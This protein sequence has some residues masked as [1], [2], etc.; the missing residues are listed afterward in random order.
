[1]NG[2]NF[3]G[4]ALYEANFSWADLSGA[5]L[6]RANLTHV[7]FARANLSQATIVEANLSH[8]RFH[9]TDLS[10]AQVADCT[11]H[12]ITAWS[13]NLEGA[14]QSNLTITD[15]YEYRVTVDN[16]AVAQF[17][18]LL[19]NNED[20]RTILNS[21]SSKV[22]LILGRFAPERK[23][24]LDRI[25][26]RLRQLDYLPV[27]FDFRQPSNRDLTET[28]TTLAHMAR[29]II[30][31]ITDPKSVPQELQA[32]VPNLPSV[33]V[34]P[35]LLS[36]AEE[37]AMFEHFKR[38]PWVLKTYRYDSVADA[39]ASVQERIINPAESKAKELQGS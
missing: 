27:I 35:L 28:V 32:I 8:S 17:V 13:V 6:T 18:Y 36:S 29:F 5:N 3:N 33:P 14:R 21:L 20:V 9:H 23:E 12:G 37:Y 7:N 19:L 22:V 16:L 24:V 10:R 11:V 26:E 39:V 15:P 4:A 38:Y 1:M 31:D 25:R 34:Q 30:A 2:V